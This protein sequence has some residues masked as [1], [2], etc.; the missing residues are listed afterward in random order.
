MASVVTIVSR[1]CYRS[2]TR[3]L[4]VAALIFLILITWKFLIAQPDANALMMHSKH[5][6]VSDG[7][8]KQQVQS[9]HDLHVPLQSPVKK[10][11]SRKR[12][13]N[14][15]DN[16]DKGK[17]SEHE[18]KVYDDEENAIDEKQ[19]GVDKAT[20]KQRQKQVKKNLFETDKLKSK[21]TKD[22]IYDE[23]EKAIDD[24]DEEQETKALKKDNEETKGN[25]Q[26]SSRTSKTNDISTQLPSDSKTLQTLKSTETI[27]INPKS[28]NITKPEDFPVGEYNILLTLVNMAPSSDLATGMRKC[29]KSICR[30][31]S[32]KI[33]VHVVVDDIG[34]MVVQD[35][36][37]TMKGKC[38]ESEVVYHNVG[39]LTRQ[40]QP[41]TKV[42]Q[43]SFS[44]A[45]SYYNNPIF[46]I[47]TA[48]YKIFPPKLTKIIMLDVDMRFFSDI[49]LLFDMFKNFKE[50]TIMGLAREQS[51][52]Y[53]HILY[54]YRQTH[55]DTLLGEPPPNGITGFNSGVVLLNLEQMRKSATYN[56]VLN[57]K[58]IKEL[59]DKYQFQGHLGDQDF[60]TLL[61]FEY[62]E[63]FYILPCSWNRQ[64]CLFWKENGYNEIFDLY[65]NCSQ[66][67]HVYH[68]NC[69]AE[70]PV[71]DEE[72]MD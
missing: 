35:F 38:R 1:F 60:F 55:K 56:N 62:P 69:R 29:L 36:F 3:P 19:N 6:I 50:S 20:A 2:P 17:E 12:L 13:V 65:N 40:L 71:K 34:E 16:L 32:I 72:D 42:L 14:K 52:V 70:I 5:G 63:L 46:F 4:F 33:T 41:I 47:S 59:T 27:A 61:S 21:L 23:K 28:T 24:K 9:V 64:L 51:P 48:L 11:E 43:E 7:G 67:I 22:Q 25:I 39:S 37:K 18:G 57:S 15:L 44:S 45:R 54:R 31:S 30:H 49:K 10:Q 58:H 26:S 68:G 66:P 53:H 8:P